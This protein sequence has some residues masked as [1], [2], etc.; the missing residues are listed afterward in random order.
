MLDF[1]PLNLKNQ[2]IS[3][4]KRLYEV[5]I[6]ADNPITVKGSNGDGLKEREIGALTTKKQIED[7]VFALSNYSIY[8]VEESLKQGFITSSSGERV[9]VCGD[10]VVENGE[11]I[12]FKN[13]T[14]LCIRF[15][16]QI[17]GCS[18]PFTD[19]IEE[20]KSCLVISPPFHGKTTFIRDLGRVYSDR[21]NKNVLYVDERDELWANGKFYLGKRADVIRNTTK[22]FAFNFGVRSYNPDVIICDELMTEEDYK[23]VSFAM[24]SGVKVVASAHSDSLENFLKKQ[25][26]SRILKNIT[27]EKIIVIEDFK[28]KKIY[29]EKDWEN[30]FSQ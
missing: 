9:G 3:A 8:S 10:A 25:E 27:F 13:F 28:I 4:F 1:L 11:I 22:S 17:V 29:G 12:T 18:K 7:L 6:R 15:P 2:I 19:N 5:R 24:L 30:C 20:V 14:S 26:I 23:G 16:N 21:F